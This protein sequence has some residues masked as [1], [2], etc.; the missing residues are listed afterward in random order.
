M[1]SAWDIVLMV[2]MLMLSGLFSGIEIAFVS[3]NKLKIELK[4]A[5]GDT[6]GTILSGFVKHT[7]RVITTILVGNNLALVIYGIFIAKVLAG[8]FLYFDIMDPV[9][10][11]YSSLVLQTVISTLVILI[12][13]EY[14]P[15]A[16]FRLK[17][18]P[19]MF[20]IWTTRFLQFFY[21]LF[22]PFVVFINGASRFFLKRILRLDYEEEELVFGKEDLNLY[23][24]ESLSTTPG[25]EDAPEIDQEMFTNAME[26]NE[27]RVREFMIPRTEI[28]AIPEDT[29]LDALIDMFIETGHSKILVY[30]EN[31]DEI[32]GFVH[33]STLFRK[34]GNL[35]EAVQ[36]IIT[37]P[38]SM[39]ANVLLTEFSKNRA[40]MALVVD[41]FGGTEGI[42]TVE[43]LV[44]EVFG[45]IE[46]EHDEPE[47]DE[48]L[49]KQIDE[50]T[51]LFHARHEVDYLNETY[52]LELPEG[53][54]TTLGGLVIQYAESIPEA[55]E[56][57][58]IDGYRFVVTDAA[59]NKVNI[60]RVIRR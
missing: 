46:D 60:V 37:V 58:D 14:L 7:P 48:L 59:D 33:S 57:V 32:K 6:A 19:I 15:K 24:Q 9:A 17:A 53:D 36:P 54:Y 20:S 16:I 55:N 26:F 13:G 52:E 50:N 40:T 42:V 21:N 45:E 38:E 11:P 12:F 4:N 22:G 5:Q 8:V 41:E 35:Q 1:I 30:G 44:E 34:P 18:E 56:T 51:W 28:K 47:E 23:L 43:D 31:L 3:S 49:A 29:D 10:N 39:A 25:A 2:V 27:T